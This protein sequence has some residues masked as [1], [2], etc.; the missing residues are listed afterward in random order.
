MFCKFSTKTIL[1]ST[2]LVWL[3]AAANLSASRDPGSFYGFWESLEPAGDT[4]VFNIKRGNRISS[5]FT[6]A[7]SPLITQGRWEMQ[8]D[9]LVAIWDSGHRD[10]FRVLGTGALERQAFRPGQ[11]LS[12]DPAYITRATRVDP[13][14]PGSLGVRRDDT[15]RENATAPAP[16]EER[17]SP[18]AGAAIP[19]RNDFNGY[20]LVHQGAGGFLGIRSGGSDHFY[21]H[22]MRNG[23]AQ[24]SQRRWNLDTNIVS[25]RWTLENDAAVIEWPNGQ[26][27]ILRES[28]SGEFSLQVFGTGRRADRPEGVLS[29]R[30]STAN[31]SAQYFNTGD[32]RLFTMSDI[33]G[34]WAPV[35]STESPPPYIHIEGWGRA[36][37]HRLSTNAQQ[38]GEWRLFTDRVV[39]TWDD[40]SKDVIR[41]GMRGWEQDRFGP[42]MSPSSPPLDTFPVRKV[43]PDTLNLGSR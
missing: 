39:I 15:P 29:A 20:W 4:C 1:F 37:Q 43:D 7:A 28:S 9:K 22:L 27:D 26:R 32:V 40:G 11:E 34:F 42:G 41:L 16:R 8:D 17:A 24:A 36:S 10:V 18:P 19:F 25:G 23:T 21:L 5:F 38:R 3:S 30:R 2:L 31:E 6:G 13:R 14:V 33:R 12:G 35:R